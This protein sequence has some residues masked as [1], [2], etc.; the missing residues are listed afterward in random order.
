MLIH[1]AVGLD[2]MKPKMQG[3]PTI[4]KQAYIIQTTDELRLYQILQV[5]EP[6]GQGT[7]QD[8]LIAT[9]PIFN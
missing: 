5:P 4:H 3:A 6:D 9:Q 7:F 1:Q 8:R 2:I